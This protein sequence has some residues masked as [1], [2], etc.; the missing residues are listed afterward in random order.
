M[1]NTAPILGGAI[2]NDSESSP[3][4]VNCIFW[5]DTADTGDEI[6]NE[7]GAVPY[8][9]YSDIEG[10]GGSG[11]IWDSL[12]GIDG[13][14]NIDADPLFQFGTDYHV[15]VTSPC[16]DTGAPQSAPPYFPADDIDGQHRPHGI[17][18]DMGA[19]EYYQ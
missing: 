14:G 9:S 12:L 5:G 16:V 4:I 17:Y 18:Y 7:W 10:C 19:D 1:G 11:A 8:I 13:G 6:Y 2:Y 3:K 15:Q